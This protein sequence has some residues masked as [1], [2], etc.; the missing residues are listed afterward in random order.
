MYH[1]GL[2][3]ALL[4]ELA[5]V[6]IQPIPFLD[7]E[8]S[9]YFYGHDEVQAQV[10][11]AD[12]L[13]GL[14]MFLRVALYLPRILAERTGLLRE[15][16]RILGDLSGVNVDFSLV[17]KKIVQDSLSSLALLW[18][19]AVVCC[20]YATMVVERIKPDSKLGSME[21][22]VWLMVITMTTVGYGDE[23]PV[24]LL[25]RS[26]V[27]IVSFFAVVHSAMLVNAIIVRLSLAR[28][29]L[30]V[31]EFIKAMG[32]KKV[33][34]ESAALY[35][36]RGIRVWMDKQRSANPA[37]RPLGDV[38]AENEGA[39]LSAAIFRD[40][41]LDSGKKVSTDVPLATTEAQVV[42]TRL[43]TG[44]EESLEK[45][46]EMVP[47]FERVLRRRSSGRP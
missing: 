27:V 32:Q 12:A 23:Y 19:V 20:A 1:A 2:L 36:Q 5:I 38:L 6:A 22:C 30:Q 14:A 18:T 16:N 9:L 37:R 29:E 39:A 25:G 46:K 42:L 8:V 11:N 7:A 21:N 26:V 3:T 47:Q 15:K 35:L 31:F 41:N 34:K 13:L 4:T 10:Y 45:V 17:L 44:V 28:E 40:K 43:E 24:T 33:L